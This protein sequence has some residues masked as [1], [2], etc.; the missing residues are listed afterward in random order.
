MKK[1]L[2]ITAVL[3]LIVMF[4]GASWLPDAHRSITEKIL[5]EKSKA[6]TADASETPA[7]TATAE[8]EEPS[9]EPDPLEDIFIPALSDTLKEFYGDNY[10][11]RYGEIEPD[12]HAIVVDV[13]KSGSSLDATFAASDFQ[14]YADQWETTKQNFI[15]FSNSCMEDLKNEGLDN[16]DFV[17]EYMHDVDN[18]KALLQVENGVIIFDVVEEMKK[19]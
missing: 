12:R 15:D 8:P 5:A 3:L 18:T 10:K 2:R 9:F 6:A 11:I 7:P 17:I 1:A 16:Y 4:M 14:D 19:Q 13:W